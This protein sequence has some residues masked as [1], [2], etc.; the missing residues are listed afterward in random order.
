MDNPEKAVDQ[1]ITSTFA[2]IYPENSFDTT[3][4]QYILAEVIVDSKEH[5][6][7]FYHR[8]VASCSD[9]TF[10]AKFYSIIDMEE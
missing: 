9:Y 7:S 5:Y 1:S 4:M 6:E 3:K 2:T 8:Q 10:R